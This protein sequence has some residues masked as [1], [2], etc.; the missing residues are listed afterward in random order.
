M[1]LEFQ[2]IGNLVHQ[3]MRNSRLSLR[4]SLSKTRCEKEMYLCQ[5]IAASVSQSGTQWD[6]GGQLAA[7]HGQ[8]SGFHGREL[9][10]EPSGALLLHTR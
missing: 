8:R 2:I 7:G 9:R 6:L 1:S 5:A 3:I 10:A 4:E